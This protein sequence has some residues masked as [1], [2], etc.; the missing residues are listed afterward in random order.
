MR[1]CGNCANRCKDGSR[2]RSRLE[3][4]GFCPQWQYGGS[5]AEALEASFGGSYNARRVYGEKDGMRAEWE[6]INKCAEF[7][8]VSPRVIRDY[9]KS[10]TVVRGWRL[11]FES[12]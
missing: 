1:D 7:F 4:N 5:N 2:R 6:S 11:S 3:R 12:D 10:G 9:A 8:C